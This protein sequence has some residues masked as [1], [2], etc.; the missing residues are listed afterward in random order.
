MGLRC[1]VRLG[2]GGRVRAK[3]VGLWV[4]VRVS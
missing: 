2:L 4:G 3:G 1:R